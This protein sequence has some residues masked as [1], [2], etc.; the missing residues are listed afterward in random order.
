M[1]APQPSTQLLPASQVSELIQSMAKAL[2]AF[3]MYLPNNP[4]YQR[5]IQN[6][7][8]AF[9]P[10][11]AATDELELKVVE[12]ELIWEEQVVYRQL[13]KSESIAWSLF[14]DGMRSSPSTRVPRTRSCPVF[15]SR[16]IRRVSL[17][18]T[19]ATICLPCSGLSSSRTSSTASS[20]SSPKAAAS[21]PARRGRPGGPPPPTQRKAARCRR[22]SGQRPK[23]VID[24]D[25]IDSTLY[26][27]DEE[28]ITLSRR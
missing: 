15:W 19:R 6:V 9:K 27:L 14:K 7:R 3:Q 4:I 18:P 20:T 23:G 2:R 22:G 16:S 5:A 17:P 25:E 13:N 12:T 26:F 28:E 21:C 8:T 10:I 24:L 11:W 1:T